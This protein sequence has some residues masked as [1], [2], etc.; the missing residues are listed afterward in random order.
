LRL[1][2]LVFA[3]VLPILIL[4]VGKF[5]LRRCDVP[6]NYLANESYGSVASLR[7]YF[8]HFWSEVMRV[9]V[10]FS[11]VM[12]LLV[13]LST[14]YAEDLA[15]IPPDVA[16]GWSQIIGKWRVEGS[17]G[18]RPITGSAVFEWAD[19]NPCYFGRQVWRIGDEG[20][21]IHLALIGGWDEA[22]NETIEQGFSS[23]GDS[24]TVRY[25]SRVSGD[26]NAVVEGN[27]VGVNGPDRRWTGTVQR[28][29]RGP[30]EFTLTTTI[31]GE[32]VHA[33]KYVR[34]IEA[35]ESNP[36]PAE[37]PSRQ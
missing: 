37:T 9:F 25:S 23:S 13:C 27:I 16:R 24:A 12:L 10:P 21:T 19:G 7:Y 34:V 4:A 32:V 28:N 5:A 30:D 15:G 17:V 35:V 36:K 29:H 14:A 20:R 2:T 1:V 31:D 22:T 18:T 26:K 8:Y 3:R 11:V 33:L 6:A